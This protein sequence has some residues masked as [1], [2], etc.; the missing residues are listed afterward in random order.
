MR[1]H[2][3]I[4]AVLSSLS[5][6]DAT[7]LSRHL[8]SPLHAHPHAPAALS[9]D[10]PTAP[11]GAEPVAIDGELI[12]D[13]QLDAEPILHSELDPESS[14]ED[15]EPSAEDEMIEASSDPFDDRSIV[16]PA[17]SPE[18]GVEVS[19]V[20]ARAASVVGLV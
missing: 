3:V 7:P 6:L 2:L 11:D 15:A 17:S 19:E 14:A 20:A 16:L 9:A 4:A 18:S 5:L 10:L 12:L 8:A 1:C 13:S